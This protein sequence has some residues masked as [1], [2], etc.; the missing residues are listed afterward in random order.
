[1]NYTL[2]QNSYNHLLFAMAIMEKKI[3][4]SRNRK[5]DVLKLAKMDQQ[6]SLLRDELHL[7]M[8]NDA[9]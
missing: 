6:L 2:L 8:C 7:D 1:M 5:A 3:P 4:I 9:K